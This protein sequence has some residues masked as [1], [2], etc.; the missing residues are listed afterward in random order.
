HLTT[1]EPTVLYPTG[2]GDEER[3][4]LLTGIIQLVSAALDRSD[5]SDA[6]TPRF[7]KSG[8]GVIGYCRQGPTVVICEGDVESETHDALNAVLSSLHASAEEIAKKLDK[9]V[10]KRGKEIGDLWR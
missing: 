9:I 8:R 3:I 7:M 6:S 2:G 5:D 1:M 4:A 10:H